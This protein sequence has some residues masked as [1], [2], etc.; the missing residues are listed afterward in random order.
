MH[1]CFA[2][3]RKWVDLRERTQKAASR[4]DKRGEEQEPE[5]WSPEFIQKIKKKRET[6]QELD[7]LE[8]GF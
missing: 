1:A 7:A 8:R 3:A 6:K 2:R 5:V 4:E